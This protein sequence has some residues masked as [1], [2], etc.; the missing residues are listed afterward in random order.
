L[1][2]LQIALLAGVALALL[3]GAAF[4][5]RSGVVARLGETYVAEVGGFKIT[6]EQLKLRQEHANVY[7]PESGTPEV[8]L[9]QLI[10][11]Y[12]AAELMKQ[13]GVALDRTTWLAEEERIERQTRDPATLAKIKYVY[14]NRHDDYLYV[15]ILPDFAQSRL[16]KLF[17]SSPSFA[18]E[19]KQ[20][21]NQFLDKVELQP[22]R[23]AV[24]AEQAGIAVRRLW[25]D[26]A[27]GMQPAES[28]SKET[29]PQV[30]A[31]SAQESQLRAELEARAG[32][33]NVEAA[34]QLLARLEALAPGTV[35]RNTL[36]TPDSFETVRLVYRKGDGAVV[37]MAAFAKPDF[38]RWFWSEAS[39][40]PVR[41]YDRTL[42]ENLLQKVG[43]A[44]QL[45]LL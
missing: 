32:E 21:A 1:S 33:Q 18:E 6:T 19:S 35:Y 30:V 44:T 36:E 38:G 9:A 16:Y 20:R 29:L 42:Q 25:V 26:P 5:V 17:R 40:I 24:E 41:I 4:L 10:Q 7:Y 13:H 11:G 39:K 37:E 45:K 28:E 12:L 27:K 8:A 43:W 14:T 31:T 15:G 2:R 3:A 22:E 34:R 23:F